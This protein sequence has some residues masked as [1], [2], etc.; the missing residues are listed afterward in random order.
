MW[1]K[2]ENNM[3]K[4][5]HN[6][7][8][9]LVEILEDSKKIQDKLSMLQKEMKDD[10]LADK[11]DYSFITGSNQNATQLCT[12]LILELA[13]INPDLD[14]EGLLVSFMQDM[15]SKATK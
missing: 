6:Y 3:I 10:I 2:E 11:E 5:T 7:S 4:D 1:L 13:R 15:A 12:F 8:L 14:G 9:R